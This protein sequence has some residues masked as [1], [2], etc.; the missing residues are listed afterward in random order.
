MQSFGIFQLTNVDISDKTLK[1]LVGWL[2]AGYFVLILLVVTG[3][4]LG[5]KYV[6]RLLAAGKI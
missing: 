6:A 1:G 5:R 4:L 3:F 2:I